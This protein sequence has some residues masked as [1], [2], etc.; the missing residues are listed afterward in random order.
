MPTNEFNIND[1]LKSGES[2]ILNIN[3]NNPSS[4]Y[5][6]LS[7]TNDIFLGRTADGWTLTNDITAPSW[8]LTNKNTDISL[9]QN[10]NLT[11]T[12]FGAVV[13]NIISETGNIQHWTNYFSPGITYQSLSESDN[14]NPGERET[15][16]FRSIL[17]NGYSFVGEN[18]ELIGGG[19]AF[20][21]CTLHSL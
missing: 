7:L 8:I 4:N 19:V 20:I 1:E 18:A 14:I 16:E 6:A 3:A 10:Y 9:H 5:F 2:T 21:K 15:I 12:N 11:P 13:S 17:T